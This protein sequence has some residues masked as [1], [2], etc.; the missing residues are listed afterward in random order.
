M[1]YPTLLRDLKLETPWRVLV[2]WMIHDARKES[3]PTLKKRL[4]EV[5]NALVTGEHVSDVSS[6][7]FM[8]ILKIL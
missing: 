3:S 6:A 7:K 1:D 2:N 5:M 4:Y 8:M